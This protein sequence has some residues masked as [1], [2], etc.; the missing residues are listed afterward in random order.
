MLSGERRSAREIANC[1]KQGIRAE[2]E[3]HALSVANSRSACT[4]RQCCRALGRCCHPH[5]R[6]ST[7]S[8]A[9]KPTP[10]GSVST[11]RSTARESP[12]ILLHGGLANAEYWGNQIKALAPYHYRDRDGQSRPWP[13]HP[14]FSAIRL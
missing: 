9:V 6:R 11:M 1:R 10:T 2:E 13:Q 5:P 8:V 12:V 4:A 3:V 14:R 7:P